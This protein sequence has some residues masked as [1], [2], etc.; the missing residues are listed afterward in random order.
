MHY[1]T[2][3]QISQFI[4]FGESAHQ[5]KPCHNAFVLLT[6]RY[7]NYKI[8][9]IYLSFLFYIDLMKCVIE[10]DIIFQQILPSCYDTIC[11]SITLSKNDANY[12]HSPSNILIHVIIAI[13][14]CNEYYL[15]DHIGLWFFT[16]LVTWH[17]ANSHR[18]DLFGSWVMLSVP[19][20][21]SK[22]HCC[23]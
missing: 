2:Q 10:Y 11:F 7:C 9:I 12:I 21:L 6:L 23:K 8:V 14:P 20:N 5:I 17:I 22:C 3:L 19:I 4:P 18:S 1:F 13:M 16:P 15:Y